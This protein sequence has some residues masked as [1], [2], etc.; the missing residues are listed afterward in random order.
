TTDYTYDTDTG[1][2]TQAAYSDG[3][4]TLAYTYD[5]L[6]RIA[7]V[8]DATG[9]RTFTYRP[10]DQ[11]P[12]NETL[13][14]LYDNRVLA[15]QYDSTTGRFTGLK[16][17][18]QSA[19]EHDIAYAYDPA[20]ARLASITSGAGT[21]KRSITYHDPCYLGRHNGVYT[22][23]REL[24]EILPG[25]EYVEMPRNSEKSFCCGAGGARMWM[26][27]KIGSPAHPHPPGVNRQGRPG[28]IA[29]EAGGARHEVERRVLHQLV[30]ERG[31]RGVPDPRGEAAL[32]RPRRA[33]AAR[34]ERAVREVRGPREAV[35][36]QLHRGLHARAHG[37]RARRRP[38]PRRAL[39]HLD[40]QVDGL[41]VVRR[42][43]RREHCRLEQAHAQLQ[44]DDEPDGG[45]DRA[46][47]RDARG[48]GESVEGA[49]P[50]GAKCPD[51][52]RSRPMIVG[53]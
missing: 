35:R 44:H 16:V 47:A 19:D 30:V 32:R 18:H 38:R 31:A 17:Q 1:E 24:L 46:Q 12:E 39:R 51:L 34:E 21:H 7:T 22:P 11:K 50:R 25:A 53:R 45:R 49:T 15:N 33:L 3:T 42:A 4:P 48:H 5:R 37:Q 8:T 40:H 29:T 36:R 28:G 20:N 41:R 2:L 27:E 14:A 6:G 26:E 13:G 10:V 9:T 43:A 23:P 52:R